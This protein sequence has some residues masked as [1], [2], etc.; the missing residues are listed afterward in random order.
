MRMCYFGPRLSF[1]SQIV[2]FFFSFFGTVHFY[3]PRGLY[4]VAMAYGA[5]KYC[6]FTRE[7]GFYCAIYVLC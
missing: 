5:V 7:Y 1:V 6:I 2:H 4:T 3:L